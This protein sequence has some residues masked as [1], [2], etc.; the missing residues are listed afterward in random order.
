M[1]RKIIIKSFN[2]EEQGDGYDEIEGLPLPDHLGNED[3]SLDN[4]TWL[5]SKK[6]KQTTKRKYE[7]KSIRKKNTN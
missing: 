4:E 5:R 6:I 7:V 1:G 3:G 2:P